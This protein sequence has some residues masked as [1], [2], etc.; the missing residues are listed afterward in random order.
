MRN[1]LKPLLLLASIAV[2][3]VAA[4]AA[5]SAQTTGT[6]SATYDEVAA[7]LAQDK[8]QRNEIDN[9]TAAIRST[10]DLKAYLRATPI[11][12]TPLGRLSPS[13]QR[14]FLASLTFNE[15]GLTGFDYRALSDELAAS[16]IYRVLGL[17]GME[18]TIALIPDVRVETPLDGAIMQHVSP[19]ACPPRGPKSRR[20]ADVEPQ[21]LCGTDHEGYKCVAPGDCQIY[22]GHICTSNC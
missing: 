10:A 13:A 19:Q 11:A 14:Q 22:N 18:R 21:L 2:I 3:S 15:N 9:A 17:F 5:D 4:Q 16:E 12:R 6:E 8:H 20:G 1:S 7:L